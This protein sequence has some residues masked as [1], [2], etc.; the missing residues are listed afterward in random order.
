MKT[1]AAAFLTVVAATALTGCTGSDDAAESAA[2]PVPQA[3]SAAE[4]RSGRCLDLDSALVTDAFASLGNAPGG[5]PWVPGTASD[6]AGGDCPALLWA[7]A[8]TPMGT[9]SS[10]TQVLFFHD[11]AYLGTATAESYAYTRVVES[12]GD[13][14]SVQY[15]WLGEQ[16]ANCCPSGGP[17]VITYSWDGSRVVM[18]QP[19][20]QEMLDSYY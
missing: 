2:S 1:R 6:A 17:A 10:P 11:G 9:V 19:L 5:D 3:A 13:S 4:V 18:E 15:R 16:D 14:V 20:P 7:T 8:E 12:T